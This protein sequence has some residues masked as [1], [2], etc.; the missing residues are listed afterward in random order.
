[1]NTSI[2]I[3]TRKDLKLEAQKIAGEIGIPLTTVI[4]SFLKQFVREKEITLSINTYAPT[5]YL[6]QIIKEA[7]AE[8]K[9]GKTAGPFSSVKDM[10][11]SLET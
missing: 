9:A 6:A 4:N 8:Y 3:K 1:M 5:P 10:I 2:L 11:K 7:R